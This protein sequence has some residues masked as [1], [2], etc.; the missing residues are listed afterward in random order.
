MSRWFVTGFWAVVAG[1]LALLL[2]FIGV[3]EYN[4]QTGTDVVL[5]AAPVDPRSLM[6]GDYAIL[7]YEIAALPT[8]MQGLTPGADVYVT[9]MERED[10]W[11]AMEYRTERPSGDDVSIKGTVDGRGVPDFGTGPHFIPKG[12]G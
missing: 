7:G 3:K 12:T 2:A 10:V 5:Q 6:Q 1:Q 11:E 9:L 8:Y 4:L